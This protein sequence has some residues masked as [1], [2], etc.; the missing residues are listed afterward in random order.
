MTRNWCNDLTAGHLLLQ[1]GNEAGRKERTCV[2]LCRCRPASQ[3]LE[4]E[5]TRSVTAPHAHL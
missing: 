1:T 2:R 5:G 3:K 4:V